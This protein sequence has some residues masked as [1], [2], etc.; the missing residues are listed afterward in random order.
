MTSR[1]R[2]RCAAV[3]ALAAAALSAGTATADPAPPSPTLPVIPP[4]PANAEAMT[5]AQPAVL[6]SL[7]QDHIVAA[8]DGLLLAE[9]E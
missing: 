6:P 8:R 2:A 9:V 4:P 3:A 5:P 7:G 1:H